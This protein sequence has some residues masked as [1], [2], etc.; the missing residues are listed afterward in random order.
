MTAQKFGRTYPEARSHP[1]R[2]AAHRRSRRP[3]AGS[4]A[5]CRRR[6][7]QS[8]V[9]A[10]MPLDA[11]RC[12][13]TSR[14][15]RAVR[16]DSAGRGARP[17]GHPTSTRAVRGGTGDRTRRCESGSLRHPRSGY[18]GPRERTWFRREVMLLAPSGVV[19][20]RWAVGHC[21]RARHSRSR[22]S[23]L[24]FRRL[25]CDVRGGE[26]VVARLWRDATHP[27]RVG[28][29]SRSR[30]DPR[31]AGDWAVGCRPPPRR[32]RTHDRPRLAESLDAS[33]QKTTESTRGPATTLRRSERRVALAITPA[34]ERIAVGSART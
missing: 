29:S 30:C 5:Q 26:L 7:P 13:G 34:A 18:R 14:R 10:A 21:S 24:V 9:L 1:T 20:F 2:S 19:C 22:R 6:R 25:R 12:R 4:H 3:R 17:P 23:P 11:P 16:G 15:C 8:V 27:P 28:G 32:V 31:S 33:L